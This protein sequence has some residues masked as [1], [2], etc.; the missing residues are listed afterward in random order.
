MSPKPKVNAR[1][2]V[3]KGPPDKTG[4]STTPSVTIVPANEASWEDLQVVLGTRGYHSGCWCQRF[5]IR[6][7]EW[8]SNSVPVK[9][10]ARR[11]REQTRCGRPEARTTSGLVAYL[12][13]DPVG[14]CA[15][16]TR[17]AYVRLG[18]VPWAG[19]TEDKTDASVWAVTCFVI[20]KGFRRRGISR[21]LARASVDFARKRGARALEG[22]AMITQPGQEITWGELHVGSR[23][24]FAASGFVEVSRPSLRRIV[25]RI[26]FEA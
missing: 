6:G 24:I 11:L 26:D 10:R 8:D 21:A 22:Y 16:E 12:D 4:T 7:T 23:S 3:A 20:R 18:R 15:V 19:R 17:S 25:M 5:K 13:S 1:A 14:W 2:S 9:E